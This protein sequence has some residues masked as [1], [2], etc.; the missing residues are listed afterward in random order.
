MTH[1]TTLILNNIVEDIDDDNTIGGL[2]HYCEL[3]TGSTTDTGKLYKICANGIRLLMTNNDKSLQSGDNYV[4]ENGKPIQ[5]SNKQ[6]MWYICETTIN[7]ARKYGLRGSIYDLAGKAG[8]FHSNQE[9]SSIKYDSAQVLAVRILFSRESECGSFQSKLESMVR[10]CFDSNAYIVHTRVYTPV[11]RSTN[12]VA[13]LSSD[14]VT[15]D[16]PDSN[17][18]SV[19]S[20]ISSPDDLIIDSTMQPILWENANLSCFHGGCKGKKC[21]LMSQ[22]SY[23]QHAD[24]ANNILIMSA[25]N[26]D[27]FDSYSPK[28]AI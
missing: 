13:V 26:H 9:K 23:I 2:R 28:I 6:A 11:E 3:S 27:R 19:Y 10:S 22:T 24:N 1:Q 12:L 16:N 21:H 18:F 8:A 14:Y 20:R 17:D 25:E 5:E 7:T 4:F 15:S